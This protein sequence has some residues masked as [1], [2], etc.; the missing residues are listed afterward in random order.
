MWWI[1]TAV[2]LLKDELGLKVAAVGDF[3]AIPG[4]A[5]NGTIKNL[6]AVAVAESAP[7][8]TT[9]YLK[10]RTVLDNLRTKYDVTIVNAG[11]LVTNP[12][13]LQFA[14][15]GDGVILSFRFGRRPVPA[16]QEIT[17]ALRRVGAQILGVVAVGEGKE[18]RPEPVVRAAEEP[19]TVPAQPEIKVPTLPIPTRSGEVV[20]T[21]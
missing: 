8:T 19:V 12:V 1:R 20:I 18:R 14:V 9:S 2:E 6:S 13:A 11:V 5:V 7:H 21:R 15:A 3:A 17:A 10:M 4:S 16:D